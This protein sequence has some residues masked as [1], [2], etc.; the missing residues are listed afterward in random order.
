M[1][2]NNKILITGGCGFIGLN[3]V[4]FLLQKTNHQ[5]H[6]LDNLSVGS[7][8]HLKAVKGFSP[9]TVSFY[10]GDIRNQDDIAQAIKGC[11]YVIHL[12]AQTGVIPSIEDPFMDAHVNILGTLN[13]L[14]M[15]VQANVKKFIC[16]SSAAPLG[17]QT[18]PLN[19]QKLPQPLSPY[20]ASKLSSEAYCS[21]Y[22]ASFNLETIVLRFSNVYGPKS[23]KKGSVVAK[24]IKQLLVDKRVEIYGTGEQTRDFI[25]VTDICNAIYLAMTTKLKNNFEIF[26]IGSGIETTVNQLFDIIKEAFPRNKTNVKN[27][28]YREKRQGEIHRNYA[29]I[30][31][32]NQILRYQPS[33]ELT[34]GVED[35]IIWFIDHYRKE[36]NV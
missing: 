12:A 14:D 27:P 34:K 26:Q 8:D 20:G 22:S 25:N 10:K 31:K 19:E 1:P 18:P 36:H 24:F 16:A 29:D 21:A 2:L 3:L 13:M 5:I 4:E 30:Q 6:V 11:K 15:A 7:L 33:V 9:T 35:T 17:E 28:I 23:Y 32:A